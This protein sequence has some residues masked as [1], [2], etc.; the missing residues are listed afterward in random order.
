MFVKI[1]SFLVMAIVAVSSEAALIVRDPTI[2]EAADLIAPSIDARVQVGDSFGPTSPG[3]SSRELLI[4]SL[5]GGSSTADFQVLESTAHP[6]LLSSTTSGATTLTYGNVSTSP[7]TPTLF[8]NALKIEIFSAFPDVTESA[9]LTFTNGNG[10]VY[11]IGML[12]ATGPN[13]RT[14]KILTGLDF[15]FTGSTLGGTVT[16]TGGLTSFFNPRAFDARVTVQLFTTVTVPEP[17][18]LGLIA[19]TIIGLAHRTRK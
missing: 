10:D 8:G 9:S 2:A 6:F 11:P 17:S 4:S 7:V 1:V 15:D 3:D 19:F 16:T 12:S 13:G 5:G 18:S 14:T